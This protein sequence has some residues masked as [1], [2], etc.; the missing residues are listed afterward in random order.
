MASRQDYSVGS[1]VR[2]GFMTLVVKASLPRGEYILANGAG[3]QLYHQVPY[4]G[5]ASITPAEAAALLA[6]RDAEAVSAKVKASR[7]DARAA[8]IN[9]LFA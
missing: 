9:A 4:N 2:V 7:V 6:A 8:A 3:T 5:A 1:T